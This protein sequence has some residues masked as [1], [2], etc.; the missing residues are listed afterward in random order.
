MTGIRTKVLIVGGG[1]GGLVLG[2]LLERAG[3]D[4]LILEQ[5]VLIRPYGSL[6]VISS[7]VLPLM[8]Q[9]GLLDEIE[10]AS[11]PFGGITLF[12]HDQ[13]VI[14]KIICDGKNGGLDHKQR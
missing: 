4:Y 14:G 7:L 13:S 3:I 10:R 8:E 5:S 9:L 6:I 12:R 11:I 2:I 1:L